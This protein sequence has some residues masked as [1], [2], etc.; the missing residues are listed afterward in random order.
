[1]IRAST[2]KTCTIAAAGQLSSVCDLGRPYEKA[3]V[4]VPTI[5]SATLVV[6][7]SRTATGT[8]VGLYITHDQTAVPVA[9]NITA[10][11]GNI[12]WEIP[13]NGVQYLWFYAGSAQTSG[14]VTFYVRGFNGTSLS[15]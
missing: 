13:L 3:V 2:W 12:F 10:G 1:M 6:R 11:T 4:Q 5:D 14:A 7:A 8:G 9:L 15:S